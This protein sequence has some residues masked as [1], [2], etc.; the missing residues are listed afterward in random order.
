MAIIK[1]IFLFIYLT[2]ILLL[3]IY[4]DLPLVNYI[5]EIGRTPMVLLFPIFLLTEIFY[6]VKKRKLVYSKFHYY[7]VLYFLAVCFISLVYSLFA[8]ISGNYSFL[9]ENILVKSIK[10]LIYLLL[11]ILYIRHLFFI[12]LLIKNE[13]IVYISLMTVLLFIYTYMIYEINSLPYTFLSLHSVDEPYWRVR[14]LTPESSYTGTIVVVLSTLVLYLTR[15]LKSKISRII[16]YFMTNIL[17][18][19]YVIVTGS[20]GF[21]LVMLITLFILFIKFINI[22]SYKS[23]VYFT[24]SLLLVTT[25]AYFYSEKI[26]SMLYSD[27]Q[28]YTST[29]TRLGTILISLISLVNNPLGVGTGGYLFSF[30]TYMDNAILIL[31]KTFATFF[32]IGNLN[33]EELLSY[34]NTEKNLGVKSGFFQWLIYGGILTIVFFYWIIKYLYKISKHS[35]VLIT[36]LIFIFLAIVIYVPLEL[37]YEIWFFIA[38]LDTFS[39]KRGDTY[40]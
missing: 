19:F 14:L 10:G 32:S 40:G 31:N 35:N 20:K 2:F 5:G 33:T 29:I 36:G 24:L 34:L 17:F 39:I 7:F 37:K 25:S 22:K 21:L 11:I 9:G 28:N 8:F 23:F 6:L 4:Q 30:S 26:L 18:I 12:F 38:F 3:T 16:S 15:S 1:K 13:K 27:L